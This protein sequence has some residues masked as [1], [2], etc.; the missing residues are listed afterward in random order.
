MVNPKGRALNVSL[1]VKAYSNVACFFG[2]TIRSNRTAVNWKD[3]LHVITSNFRTSSS[4]KIYKQCLTVSCSYTQRV[5]R[6]S[7]AQT[8]D[9]FLLQVSKEGPVSKILLVLLVTCNQALSENQSQASA[10][11]PPQHTLKLS[12]AGIN[13][14]RL[15]RETIK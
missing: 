6:A 2:S 12:L 8:H 10:P 14:H 13:L 9:T 4:R 15:V 3:D 7:Q 5:T 11:P 1:G